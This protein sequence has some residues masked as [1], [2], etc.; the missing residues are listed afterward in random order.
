[1]VS[2]TDSTRNGG[3]RILEL[4]TCILSALGPDPK[5]NCLSANSIRMIRT[6]T[7]EIQTLAVSVSEHYL[8]TVESKLDPLLQEMSEVKHHQKIPT[9]SHVPVRGS[10]SSTR[11]VSD[12]VIDIDALRSGQMSRRASLTSPNCYVTLMILTIQAQH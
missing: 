10:A 6:S 5:R 11:Q 3:S 4:C 7:M 9:T 2:I 1:M 12:N 8:G